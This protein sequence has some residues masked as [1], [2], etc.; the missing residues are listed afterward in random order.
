VTFEAT[1][2]NYIC[3]DEAHLYKNLETQSSIQATATTG[4]IRAT[5][6]NLKLNVLRERNG[7]RV[8]TLATATPI[9]NSIAEMH[10]MQRYLQPDALARAGV[11]RFD[12]WAAN[13][14]RTVTQ[15]ELA[16]DGGSYRMNTRFA[17]FANVPDLTTMFRTVADVRS[18]ADLNL[19]TPDLTG[20]GPETVIVPTTATLTAYVESLVDR[21][22]RVR[23]RQVTPDEDNMLKV[24]G[25]GR[26]AALD[27]R[28]VGEQPGHPTKAE[29]VADRVADI[30][31]AHAGDRFVDPA[32]GQL[33]ER[34]GAL[35]LVFCDLGTPRPGAWSVYAELRD[36]LTERGVPGERVR[37]AHEA[38]TDQ[39][40]ADLLA[41]CR[42]GR[43]SVLVGSTEKM[44]VGTNV[45]NRAVALHHMD[46]PWRPADLAQ[47]DGRIIRQGNQNPKVQ[48]IR[49]ATEASFDVYMWETVQRKQTFVHQITAGTVAER[50]VEDVGDTALSFA[51][52]KA[53]ASGNPLIIEHAELTAD[54]TRLERLADAHRA[55]Q[56]RLHRIVDTSERTAERCGERIGQYESAAAHRVDTRG[57]R[58]TMAVTGHEH[59]TR[60]NA[61]Q[62]LKDELAR[63]L[64]TFEQHLEPLGRLAG[65]ELQA[66]SPKARTPRRRSSWPT[67][68]SR[69]RSTGP[70]SWPVTPS[71]SSAGSSNPSRRSTPN[72]P[73]PA[74]NT[75]TPS[76]AGPQPKPASDSRSSTPNRSRTSRAASPR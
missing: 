76:N 63:R 61:G 75:T 17:R 19:A 41:A 26:R 27:L 58:F 32:T 14:A 60:P 55:D 28:L 1:G 12:A 25:D 62:A 51:E 11:T 6:L 53:L 22:E 15:L 30:H 29:I 47:R 72:S 66:R 21:A 18:A 64:R 37:F 54:V 33:A 20:G 46:C 65:F 68:R 13:F 31:H 36:Q 24:T 52:V 16:P 10:V 50:S 73:P 34:A 39:A 23:N 57:D 3:L 70:P 71:P 7:A 56:T 8:A 67:P 44:G 9:A 2:I 42:D 5:D 59:R 69:S 74:P 35:Q 48:V 43:V 40:K 4:S 49:Y 38:G 45:Q